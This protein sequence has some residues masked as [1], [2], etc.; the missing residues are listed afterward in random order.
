MKS[1]PT[2]NISLTK[3]HRQQ[4]RKEARRIGVNAY[5][6]VQRAPNLPKGLTA[7]A[8]KGWIGGSIEQAPQ[9]HVE[10]VTAL[11]ASLPDDGGRTFADGTPMSPRA[12]GTFLR[13]N[14]W[15]SFTAELSAELRSEFARTGAD[16]ERLLRGRDDRPTGLSPRTVRGWLYR[17]TEFTRAEHWDYVRTLLASLDD[18]SMRQEPKPRAKRTPRNPLIADEDLE[19]LRH[20]RQ[21]TGIGGEVLLRGATDKPSGLSGPM[22][23]SWLGGS[24]QNA[25]PEH[26]RYVLA[27]YAARPDKKPR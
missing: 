19:A 3:Q 22:I 6:A 10:F 20:H 21:R 26:V 8:I 5:L 23:S 13:S 9:H 17:H 16:P 7:K 1:Q 18:N 4:L 12:S 11:W 24:V 25:V 15:I 27:R 14:G 2:Q